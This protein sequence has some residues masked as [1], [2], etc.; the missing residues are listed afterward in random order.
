MHVRNLNSI[1]LL[2]FAPETYYGIVVVRISYKLRLKKE[3]K[4]SSAGTNKV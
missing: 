4:L 1:V 3:F 2:G